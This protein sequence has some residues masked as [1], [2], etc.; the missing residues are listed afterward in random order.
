MTIVLSSSNTDS[1]PIGTYEELLTAIPL[2]ANRSDLT[3]ML[4]GFVR[5]FEARCNRDLR[6][7][8]METSLTSTALVD[9]AF[10]L[11]SGFLAFKE[12]R[13]DG[14][15]AYTLEPRPAEWIRD[16]A[17]L[18]SAP[19]YFAL[20]GDQCVCY[21]TSGSVKGTYYTEIPSLAAN[22]TN[23]LLTNHPDAYLWG[24][25]QEVAMYT[26]DANLAAAASERL[27]I[28]LSSIEGTDKANSLAGGPLT[29]RAR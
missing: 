24:A 19:L 3:G 23:W 29:V 9:G 12:L 27:R 13:Y 21:P 28:T 22:S 17:D 1:D 6:V 15:P 25:L 26:R 10:T 4:P 14:S 8:A 2:W 20:T 11:P 18:A 16:Q 5:L 7:R